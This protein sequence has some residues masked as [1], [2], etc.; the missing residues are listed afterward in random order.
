MTLIEEVLKSLSEKRQVFR[1]EKDFQEALCNEIRL[2]GNHCEKGKNIHGTRVDLYWEE[3]GQ[4]VVV[5]LRHKTKKLSVVVNGERFELKNH[6]AQDLGRYDFVKDLQSIERLCLDNP[7]R[8]GYVLL[9]T[10]EHLYWQ[11]P[12]KNKSV[13]EEFLLFNG[14]RISGECAWKKEASYGTTNGREEPLLLR[15]EYKV[16]WK[17]Y[18]TF[19]AQ[20]SEFRYLCVGA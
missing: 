16:E 14:N 5:Q 2:A 19:P 15:G 10:N 12:M 6:G 7:S 20:N 13:D 18:S 9:L 3:N 11:P 1:S 4:E 8:V 17:N